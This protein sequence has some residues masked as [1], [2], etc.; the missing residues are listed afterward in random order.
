MNVLI[1]DDSKTN[2][3]LL[4]HLV[5]RSA[6][7]DPIAFTDPL[8]AMEWCGENQ[9][10]LVLLDYM[11]P[12]MDGISFLR[13]FR[14]SEKNQHVPVV[15]VT[16]IDAREVRQVA[17]EAGATDFLSKPIDGPEL[18]A[19]L[20]NLL[21]LRERQVEVQNRATWLAQE[22]ATATREILAREEELIVRLSRASECRDPETGQHILRMAHYARLI[23][24]QLGVNAADTDLLFKAAPMHD[25]GKIGIPD[26]ILLK[27]GRLSHEEFAVMKTHASIGYRLMADSPSKML[28]TGAEIAHS[29]HEKW[30][31]TGYPRGL[32]GTDIPIFGRIVA[33]ADVFDALTSSRPYKPAWDFERAKAFLVEQSGTHFDSACVEALL[34][35]WADVLDIHTRFQDTDVPDLMAMSE[36]ADFR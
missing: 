30:D 29:H 22:V 21:A 15:F 9:A 1:V 35:R 23:A 24:E 3:V 5:A 16:T 25:I 32:A 13:E 34:L 26:V 11:M 20:K 8:A 28:I 33:V 7:V 27:P 31:G 36:V 14:K 2:A 19:R 10:D 12:D 4:R 17:L 18:Q 6:A